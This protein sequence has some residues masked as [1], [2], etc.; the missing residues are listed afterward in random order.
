MMTILRPVPNE[1]NENK[2]SVRRDAVIESIT[3]L[4]LQIRVVYVLEINC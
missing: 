1:S 3:K 2:A 4:S